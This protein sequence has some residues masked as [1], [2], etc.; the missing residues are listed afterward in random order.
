MNC[1][2]RRKRVAAVLAGIAMA[3]LGAALSSAG[4]DDLQSVLAQM[5]QKAANFKSAKAEFEWVTYTKAV[6]IKDTQTGQVYFRRSGSDVDAAVHV[7]GPAAKQVVYRDGRVSMYEPRIDQLTEHTVSK[8]KADIDALMSLGFGGRG[9]DLLKSFDVKFAGWETI[10]KTKIKT[11]KLEL[12]P[13]DP[14]L[15]AK[16]SRVDMWIDLTRDVAV[17]QQWFFEA[18]GDYKL[19]RYTEIK[20]NS[21]IS[22]DVFHLKTT[23]KTTV[24]H[25]Q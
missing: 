1:L 8:N 11:A 19:A 4:E 20:V 18:S 13:K 3:M 2:G 17:Q 9:D 7:S 24:V 5:N 10:G 22:D 14:E 25:L 16:F 21:P 15:K 23:K 6:D 12:V